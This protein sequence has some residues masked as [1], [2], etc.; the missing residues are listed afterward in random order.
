MRSNMYS[1]TG[2]SGTGDDL[3]GLL[4]ITILLISSSLGIVKLHSQNV[5][6]SPLLPD[7]FT[8]AWFVVHM[9][10]IDSIALSVTYTNYTIL[11]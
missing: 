6:V 4:T 1:V 5:A 10:G 7:N 8:P 9:R 2:V 11:F 3:Y